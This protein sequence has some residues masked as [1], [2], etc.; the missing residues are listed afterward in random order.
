M[1]FP[2]PVTMTSFKLFCLACC[3]AAACSSCIKD[4]IDLDRIKSVQWSPDVALPLVN[5]TMT[6]HD[7]LNRNQDIHVQVDNTNFC[8][9]MYS[10]TLYTISADRIMAI[11]DQAVKYEFSMDNTLLT[12]FNVS[13]TVTYD[14]QQHITFQ[15]AQGAEID[16]ILL[17]GGNLKLDLRS[18]FKDKVTFRITLPG[19]VKNGVPFSRNILLAYV[20]SVPVISTLN[21]DLTGYKLD[22]TN[23]GTA[24][25]DLTVDYR[26]I[27]SGSTGSASSTDKV[28]MDA[29]FEEM[30]F[31]SIY[32]YFGNM[33]LSNPPDT[34]PLDFF[35]AQPGMGSFTLA[36]P[37]L[38]VTII[39]SAGIPVH[40]SIPVFDAYSS[41]GNYPLNTGIPNPLPLYSPTVSQIGQSLS[42]SFILNTANS[43]IAAVINHLPE[44]FIYQVAAIANPDGNVGQNF[45]TDSSSIAMC[46]DLEIP[47]YG[48]AKD[49]VIADTADFKIEDIDQ[50]ESI[51][52]RTSFTN[53][54]PIDV[55]VQVYF[56]DE[57]YIILDS[58]I[59]GNGEVLK[60]AT[61]NSFTGKVVT[62]V[63]KTTDISYDRSHIDKILHAKKII[64][65]GRAST[66]NNGN[67]NVKLYADYA[68]G[69]Q[70]GAR[71]KVN[72]MQ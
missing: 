52:M 49:F 55:N 5:T 37:K 54:F 7:I 41:A 28:S 15:P 46:A 50:V 12:L 33:D 25:N 62:P 61:V 16:S 30:K 23:S 26:V 32:G 13:G 43:N 3:L 56:T 64:T 22:I 40:A 45:I 66:T 35:H 18:T 58:L 57:N 27:V 24:V 44:Y 38:K 53:G 63:E 2:L 29:S 31:S 69:V 11:R 19:L 42:G 17:K 70:I 9:F 71:V 20:S 60:S 10:D 8:T 67:T 34:M 72:V 65:M 68:L 6:F 47:L 4:D 59:N 39:N 36:D 14:E 48:S 51:Q 21:I 1:K